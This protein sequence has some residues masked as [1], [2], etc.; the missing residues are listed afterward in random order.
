M[1]D[2]TCKADLPMIKDEPGMR[3]RFQRGL[4]RALNTPKHRTSSQKPRIKESEGSGTNTK[5]NRG[6]QG[7]IRKGKG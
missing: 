1:G 4:R 2:D 6:H 7:A 3:E 5:R